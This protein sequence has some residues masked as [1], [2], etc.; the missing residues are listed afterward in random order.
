MISKYSNINDYIVLRTLRQSAAKLIGLQLYNIVKEYLSF[1]GSKITNEMWNKAV[2]ANNTH[3]L[4]AAYT[5]K[6]KDNILVSD[7]YELYECES[8]QI[9][10]K[11]HKIKDLETMIM[12]KDNNG[13]NSS[14][15]QSKL[16]EYRER[17]LDEFHEDDTTNIILTTSIFR[18]ASGQ[19]D[20][21]IQHSI[22]QYFYKSINEVV[23][24]ETK[25]YSYVKKF[26]YKE[27][28]MGTTQFGRIKI[29]KESIEDTIMRLDEKHFQER[30]KY[31]LLQLKNI[32]SQLQVDHM[33]FL[34]KFA[35]INK[36]EYNLDNNINKWNLTKHIH[37]LV[38][39]NMVTMCMLKMFQ[40]HII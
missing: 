26:N 9:K 32:Y 35:S 15:Y 27:T 17:F 18:P 4:R 5:N 20:W 36:E 37:Q 11:K 2:D 13:K 28:Q 1:D 10:I 12:L 16:K 38:A 30:W 31:L 3:T 14:I 25:S 33:V 7:Q 24:R 23:N 21:D 40:K 6:Y 39:I 8:D 29:T 34:E 22:T 19:L